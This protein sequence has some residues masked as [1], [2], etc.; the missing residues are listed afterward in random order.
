MKHRISPLLLAVVLTSP[1]VAVA[2]YTVQVGAY[3]KPEL[4][5]F[6]A[7][8]S[9]GAVHSTKMSSGLTQF[10]VGQYASNA[11]AQAALA[12]LK[13]AGFGDAFVTKTGGRSH[14]VSSSRKTHKGVQRVVARQAK[15]YDG[16]M[17]PWM[18]LPAEIRAKLVILDGRPHIKEGGSFTPLA[19]YRGQ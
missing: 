7:A 19:Q 2:D 3:N 10:S 11:E 6:K 16:T 14:A 12:S 15:G 5:N 4:A 13:A 8:E 1:A 17:A 18:H 9:V